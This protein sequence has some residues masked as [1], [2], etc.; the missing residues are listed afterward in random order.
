MA[1]GGGACAECA[2]VAAL[3]CLPVELARVE[4]VL[5]GG[6]F[7][8]HG[9]SEPRCARAG[10]HPAT[11][12]SVGIYE[13]PSANTCICSQRPL[14]FSMSTSSEQWAWTPDPGSAMRSSTSISHSSG[15]SPCATVTCGTTVSNL[16]SN[17][18]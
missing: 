10:C 2:E 9:R 15:S 18:G 17:G 4:P 5:A 14:E 16:P 7:P 3:A 12:V 6:E 1:L 8:D 11:T 13:P